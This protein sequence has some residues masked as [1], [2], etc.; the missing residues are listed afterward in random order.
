MVDYRA[1]L[2]DKKASW[3]VVNP[4]VELKTLARLRT[5]FRVKL[6][7]EYLEFFSFSNG[8]FAEIPVY[9]KFCDL[10]M[11]E[12]IID[13][14]GDYGIERRFPGYVAIGSSGDGDVFIMRVDSAPHA[15]MVVNRSFTGAQDEVLHVAPSFQEFVCMFGV[16]G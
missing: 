1:L 8:A 4:P 10:F 5:K 11:L 7:D 16:A 3:Q 9:P 14:E 15:V 6:P 2:K 12:D 13:Y